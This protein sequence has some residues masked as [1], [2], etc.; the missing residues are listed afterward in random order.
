MTTAAHV[1][2]HPVTVADVD[3]REA[4]LRRHTPAAALPIPGTGEGRQLRR[5]LTQLI[6]TERVV[7]LEAARRGLRAGDAPD[8][9][10]ILPDG[11]ARHEVGSVIA[12]A[13]ADPLARALYV[14]LTR[15]VT[16]GDDEIAAYH[17]RNPLRF[18]DRRR[19]PDGWWSEPVAPAL[20]Q[21]RDQV[22]AHL[23]AAA[24]RRAFRISLEQL[25]AELV[26]LAPGFEHPGDPRQPDNTHRH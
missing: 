3:A 19:G 11:T 25:R 20:A 8:L 5:W 12:A 21:V 1:D 26:R 13:L 7:A 23:T 14:D 9:A 2:G 15:D 4:L 22:A 24:R 10:E 6:V 16:V 17:R 18:A